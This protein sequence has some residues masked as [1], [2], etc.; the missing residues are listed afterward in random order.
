MTILFSLG[1]YGWSLVRNQT[2]PKVTTVKV[3]TVCEA[4]FPRGSEPA[5]RGKTNCDGWANALGVDIHD[6]WGRVLKCEMY[7]GRPEVVSYGADGIPGGTGSDLDIRC[8]QAEDG[9]GCMC[10]FGERAP[11]E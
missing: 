1:A 9:G 3:V 8:W 5:R 7:E 4:A 2:D 10:V 6:K 11:V